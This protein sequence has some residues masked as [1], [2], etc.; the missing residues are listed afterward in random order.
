MHIDPSRLWKAD[1]PG[2]V[3]VLDA[4]CRYDHHVHG[5][6]LQAERFVPADVADLSPR[7]RRTDPRVT[8]RWACQQIVALSWLVLAD[9][10]DGLRPLRMETRGA[11]ELD[12]AGIVRAFLTDMEALETV[13][14]V[15]WG[16]FHKDLPQILLAA[17]A[18]GLHLPACL[19]RLHTPWR[20]HSSGHRDLMTEMCA[21]ASS[22]H[23]AEVAAK[24][25][26]PAKV[27][28]RPDLVSQLMDQGK[29]SSVKSVCEGDVLT[30]AMILMH[31][32]HLLGGSTSILEATRRL[33]G[34]V[35]AHCGHRSYAV[36]WQRFGDGMLRDAFA[37]EAAKLTTLAATS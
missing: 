10:E 15:T 36:D 1:T 12:E 4:E 37:A 33:C 20:R 16:G 31:W 27:T 24:F 13:E 9:T 30:T 32:R 19:S 14:L 21:G 5:R 28:C 25:G 11:P 8:P 7:D 18:A 23:L 17:A 2:Y 26:V 35:T 3:V 29:W 34:F 22:P 6:Y